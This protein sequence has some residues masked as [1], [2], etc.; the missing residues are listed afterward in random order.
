MWP[1]VGLIHRRTQQGH[2]GPARRVQKARARTGWAPRL[3][4]HVGEGLKGM[5]H[6]YGLQ[7]CICMGCNLMT[8]GEWWV[9][10]PFVCAAT[11]G[12]RKVTE[13]LKMS[14]EKPPVGMQTASKRCAQP[15]VVRC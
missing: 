5:M 15:A 8:L 10:G 9:T 6:M 13:G 11:R 14:L 3:F 1:G 4:M 2:W 7:A 12:R